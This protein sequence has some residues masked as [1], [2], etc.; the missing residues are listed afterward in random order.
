MR[1]PS[2]LLLSWLAGLGTALAAAPPGYRAPRRHYTRQ[3]KAYVRPGVRLHLSG[4]LATYNGDLTSKLSDN[5]LHVGYG[6]GITHPLSPRVTFSSELSW[7]R[8]QAVDYDKDRNFRFNSDNYLL[9]GTVRYNLN[10]DRSLYLGADRQETAGNVFVEAGAAL[11]LTNPM[12]YAPDGQ[13]G[14]RRLPDDTRAGY[15]LLAAAF[16]VGLGGTLRASSNLAFT[17][18]ALYYFTTTDLLDNVSRLANPNSADNFATLS[19]KVEFG[20]RKK[21]GQPLTHND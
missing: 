11:L 2:L 8:L 9:A 10:Q 20:F 5:T 17:V 12:S 18:D 14:F 7:V 3:N 13:G 4:N 15:P 19:L 16:P 6:I 1:L 21:H